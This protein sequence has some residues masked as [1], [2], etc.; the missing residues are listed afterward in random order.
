M[1]ILVYCSKNGYACT[2]MWLIKARFDESYDPTIS[3]ITHNTYV[4]T[5]IMSS[6]LFH[7][8]A[9]RSSHRPDLRS[10]DSG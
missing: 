3:Y 8:K 10:A 5:S 1:Y 7:L 4:R 2:C 9:R 6:F